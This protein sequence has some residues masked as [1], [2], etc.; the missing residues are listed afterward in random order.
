MNLFAAIENRRINLAQV[1]AKGNKK[2][3]SM[4]KAS[5]GV[6]DLKNMNFTLNYDTKKHFLTHCSGFFPLEEH[7]EVENLIQRQISFLSQAVALET[8]LT[9][10]DLHKRS[11]WVWD[12]SFGVVFFGVW[13]VWSVLVHAEK[14]CRFTSLL[15][16]V[17]W[18]VVPH[19]M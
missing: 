19:C 9:I 2:N 15:A 5:R 14:S 18:K 16:R 11:I 1:N 10:D 8:I 13:F 17:I 7:L 3:Q 6:R 12:C 4:K